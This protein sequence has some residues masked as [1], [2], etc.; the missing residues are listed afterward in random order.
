MNNNTAGTP[1]KDDSGGKMKQVENATNIGLGPR[2]IQVK[3]STS[4]VTILKGVSTWEGWGRSRS[5]WIKLNF[6]TPWAK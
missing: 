6:G 2:V 5:C 3:A 4:N 1:A